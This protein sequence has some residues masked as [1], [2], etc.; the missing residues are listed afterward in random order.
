MK[1]VIL[2]TMALSLTGCA[3]N[4]ALISQDGVRYPMTAN[5]LGKTIEVT[6]DGNL[7]KGDYVIDQSV[8]FGTAQAYSST[9]QTSAYGT[10]VVQGNNG[11]AILT[12]ATGEYLEC[13]FKVSGST[14]VGKCLSNKG[15]QFVLTTN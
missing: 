14:G 9:K 8:G 2:L 15:R 4:G 10:T 12:S 7:F 5:R 3:I 11:Q 1:K 6:I 13:N